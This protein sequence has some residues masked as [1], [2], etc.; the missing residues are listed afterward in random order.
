MS[1]AAANEHDGERLTIAILLLW[2]TATAIMLAMAREAVVSLGTNEP[3]TAQ[4]AF[5]DWLLIV[6][7]VAVAPLGG[8]GISAF[9]LAIHRWL[10]SGPKFPSQP[11]HLL[12]VAIGILILASVSL[13]LLQFSLSSILDLSQFGPSDHLANLILRCGP[14]AATASATIWSTTRDQFPRYWQWSLYVSSASL[15][16]VFVWVGFMYDCG[17]Y[18]FS[19]W[20]VGVALAVVVFCAIDSALIIAAS[21]IDLIARRRY[22]VFHWA[23]IVG[24]PFLLAALLITYW[25]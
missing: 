12:L 1:N 9:A 2:I 20:S 10:S 16:A 24:W 4:E 6:V 11:G 13:S 14:A 19:T 25:Y 21:A 17:F 18:V 3:D 22:D 8:A 7:S 5:R 15:V 23:G